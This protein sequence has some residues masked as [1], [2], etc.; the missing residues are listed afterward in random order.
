LRQ[1][2]PTWFTRILPNMSL[3]FPDRSNLMKHIVHG[4][5]QGN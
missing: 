2:R 5:L 1:F 3:D 4:P